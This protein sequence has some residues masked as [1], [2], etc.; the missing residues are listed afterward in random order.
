[1][2]KVPKCKCVLVAQIGNSDQRLKLTFY[3]I[4]LEKL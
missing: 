3:Q 2:A 4:I 1:M